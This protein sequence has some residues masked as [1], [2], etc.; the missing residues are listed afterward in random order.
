VQASPLL[1]WWWGLWIANGVLGQAV[2]RAAKNA[3]TVEQLERM[4]SISIVA[5]LVG[6]PLCLIAIKLVKSI[7][8]MQEQVVKKG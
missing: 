3:N 2:F 5:S 6:I 4:T 7:A 1:G 8:T